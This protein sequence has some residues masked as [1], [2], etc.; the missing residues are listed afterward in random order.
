M[1][2]IVGIGGVFFKARDPKA[3]AAWYREHLGVP[4]EYTIEY[5]SEQLLGF[6]ADVV[7]KDRT[8]HDADAPPLLRPPVP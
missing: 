1:E 6:C 5:W 7:R 8:E 3:L 2:R 4:V